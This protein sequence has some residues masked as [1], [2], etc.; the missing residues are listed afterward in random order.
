MKFSD[1]YGSEVEVRDERT[2]DVSFGTLVTVRPGFRITLSIGPMKLKD[3]KL[4]RRDIVDI[5]AAND[6]VTVR[7]RPAS[8]KVMKVEPLTESAFRAMGSLLQSFQE[9]QFD[10]LMESKLG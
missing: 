1:Y 2:G 6:T 5:N 7:T 10:G 8:V 9:E 4:G 3:I